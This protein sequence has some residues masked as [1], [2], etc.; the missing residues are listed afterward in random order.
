[1]L[2][3]ELF[4]IPGYI[5]ESLQ[6]NNHHNI[7]LPEYRQKVA[8][9]W[10][11]VINNLS[12]S[13]T[14]PKIYLDLLPMVDRLLILLEYLPSHHEFDEVD[15]LCS[16]WIQMLGSSEH[17][18]ATLSSLS[19]EARRV[20]LR[21]SPELVRR[22][23]TILI[24][25]AVLE[26]NVIPDR[27][28][29]TATDIHI[30][31]I[32]QRHPQLSDHVFAGIRSAFEESTDPCTCVAAIGLL[33]SV[34]AT[35]IANQEPLSCILPCNDNDIAQMISLLWHTQL[36]EGEEQRL[37]MLRQPFS[38][39]D[40]S[41]EIRMLLL[42]V[43]FRSAPACMLQNGA[44]SV[45]EVLLASMLLGT[46]DWSGYQLAKD[47]II[48]VMSA[49][50][51]PDG[52]SSFQNFMADVGARLSTGTK[53]AS[54]PLQQ[55][56]MLLLCSFIEFHALLVD[57]PPKNIAS[58]L[59]SLVYGSK[60]LFAFMI[61]LLQSWLMKSNSEAAVIA[62]IAALESVNIDE[63]TLQIKG[64]HT[65][66]L[67]AK[68]VFQTLNDELQRQLVAFYTFDTGDM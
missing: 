7:L 41:F 60:S 8:R 57:P 39:K 52:I 50:T 5:S 55:C 4:A 33:S 34:V 67:M 38:N 18:L 64:P 54:Q 19:L 12:E 29:R 62:W 23:V 42:C 53:A 35:L 11:F 27:V 47:D 3:G 14:E 21:L 63:V 1:M 36:T 13:T 37:S 30:A 25:D 9:T 66:R 31:F 65:T 6:D 17:F 61:G 45:V 49:R 32:V 15:R 59:S 43:V 10:D 16:Q 48:S 2:T 58:R 20:L 28:A 44:R 40:A 51:R 22:I 56:S 46:C 24:R 68:R 26:G